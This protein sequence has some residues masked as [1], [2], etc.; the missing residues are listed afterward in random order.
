MS[1]VK[2]Y[3]Y[4]LASFDPFKGTDF[5]EGESYDFWGVLRVERLLC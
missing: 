1:D 5:D 2:D 4:D 3:F